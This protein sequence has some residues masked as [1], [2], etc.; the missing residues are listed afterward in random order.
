MKAGV[1][2][3]VAVAAVGIGSTPVIPSAPPPIPQAADGA[4]GTAVPDQGVNGGITASSATTLHFTRTA[5]S[6]QLKGGRQRLD[7][8][9]AGRPRPAAGHLSA[10]LVTLVPTSPFGVRISPITGKPDEFHWGQDFAAP[11]GTLVYAADAGVVRAAGWHPWGG[12][13]RVEIDHGNGL[14]T[15]YNHLQGIAVSAGEKVQVGQV[16][17]KVGTTGASTG[18]HLHFET[19]KNGVFTD[20]MKWILDPISQQAPLDDLVFTDFTGTTVTS[21]WTLPSGGGA[22]VTGV[23]GYITPEAEK[24]GGVVPPSTPAT[25]STPAPSPASS[26]APAPK[27]SPSPTPTPTHS[28]TPTP[29]PTP[30]PTATTPPPTPTTPAPAPTTPAPTPTTP[31]PAPTTPAP[32]PTPTPTPTVAPAPTPTSSTTTTSAPAPAATITSAPAPATAPAPAP[33]TIQPTVAP[34][35]TAT[36]TAPAPAPTKAPAPAPTAATAALPPAEPATTGTTTSTTTTAPA[37]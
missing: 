9:I 21:L 36:V 19:I 29:T 28:V 11:C 35:P 2:V 31:A 5:L 14:V 25:P 17:A 8:A 16:I 4:A 1:T 18:C 15:T 10:P 33:T 13:N 30:T 27:P 22:A 37:P 24:D 6:T 26:P 20:P 34:A 7:V 32:T 23:P 3:A 12:G